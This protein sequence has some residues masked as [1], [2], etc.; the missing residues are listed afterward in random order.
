MTRKPINICSFQSVL[1]LK[2]L[3]ADKKLEIRKATI[4]ITATGQLY[5]FICLIKHNFVFVGF[6][7]LSI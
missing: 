5:S 6:Y 3:T 4:P 7:F 2:Q 1:V